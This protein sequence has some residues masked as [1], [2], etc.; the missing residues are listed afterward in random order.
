MV[1]DVGRPAR[2]T[3]CCMRQSPSFRP[4]IAAATAHKSFA[5]APIMRTLQEYSSGVGAIKPWP[6]FYPSLHCSLLKHGSHVLA[7]LTP[8]DRSNQAGAAFRLPENAHCYRT[9]LDPALG[10]FSQG[11]AIDSREPT[12]APESPS[13]ADA[14]YYHADC[15]MLRLDQ[16]PKDPQ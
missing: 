6:R 16:P 9:A 14:A 4:L 13:D 1:V 15:I 8:C 2:P 7:V 5:S 12:P 10:G 3:S 11:P